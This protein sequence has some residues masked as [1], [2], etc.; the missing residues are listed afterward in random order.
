VN[1][2]EQRDLLV[3]EIVYALTL[4]PEPEQGDEI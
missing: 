1:G 4:V 3:R 2:F